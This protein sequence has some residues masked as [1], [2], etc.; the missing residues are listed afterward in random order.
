MVDLA[1]RSDFCVSGSLTG[2][3]YLKEMA[4]VVN[5]FIYMTKF[6]V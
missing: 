2:I 3:L 6:E 4:Q 1:G 5:Y